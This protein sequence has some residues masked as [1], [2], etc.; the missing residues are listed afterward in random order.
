MVFNDIFDS[1]ERRNNGSELTHYA[2]CE[3]MVRSLPH[4][5]VSAL[6]DGY[7]AVA[8]WRTSITQNRIKMGAIS[9]QFLIALL[10]FLGDGHDMPAF[11]SSY[12]ESVCEDGADDLK[13]TAYW[14]LVGGLLLTATGILAPIGAVVI[15]IGGALFLFAEFWWALC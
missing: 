4:R 2:A 3:A 15:P 10:I 9:L 12:S 8:H 13:R 14:L 6:S 5:L 7:S 1:V 11:A